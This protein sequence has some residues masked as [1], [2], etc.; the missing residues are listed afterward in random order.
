MC[1]TFENKCAAGSNFAQANTCELKTNVTSAECS[2]FQ[3][4]CCA[5]VTCTGDSYPKVGENGVIDWGK[6]TFVKI[7]FCVS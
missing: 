4:S 7:M 3:G 6:L 1:S 5:A 2:D